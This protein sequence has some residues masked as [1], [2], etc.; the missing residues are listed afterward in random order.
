MSKPGPITVASIPRDRRRAAVDVL[1][2]AFWDYPETLHLLPAERRRRHVLPCY[3]AGD[4]ADSQVHDTLLGAHLAGDLV[5]VAAWLPPEGYPVPVRRQLAQALHLL[6]ALPWA[7]GAAREA[8]AAQ[9]ANRSHHPREPHY[10]LR[11]IGVAP[12]WQGQGVGRALLAPT[13][14][15]AD[16]DGLGCYLTTATEANVAW[17]AGAGFVVRDTFRPTPTWPQTWSMWRPPAPAV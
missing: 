2:Q 12:R 14:A 10:Y 16:A 7:L 15:R 17:Y 9:E 6:P 8:V 13:L 11:A 5:G 1:V 4:C 3:L